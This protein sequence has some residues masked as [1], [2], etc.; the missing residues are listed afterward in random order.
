MLV[1]GVVAVCRVDGPGTQGYTS[2]VVYVEVV[3]PWVPEKGRGAPFE[4]AVTD[5]AAAAAE[6]SAFEPDEPIVPPVDLMLCQLPLMSPY[7]Y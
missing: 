2:G 4:M 6:A 5:G 3:S 7:V 1:T